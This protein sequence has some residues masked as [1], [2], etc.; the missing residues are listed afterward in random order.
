MSKE[1]Y[2]T[3]LK[4]NFPRNDD[5]SNPQN[6]EKVIYKQQFLENNNLFN[7]ATYF[8]GME[9]MNFEDHA[10]EQKLDVMFMEYLPTEMEEK[11]EYG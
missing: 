8:G 6:L 7:P 10:L 2:Y 1:S 3:Q 9:I 5:F 11:S 4:Q